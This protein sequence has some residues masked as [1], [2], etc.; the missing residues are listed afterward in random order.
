VSRGLV[1]HDG[2]GNRNVLRIRRT[3]ALLCSL[4]ANVWAATVAHAGRTPPHLAEWRILTTD[5]I[6]SGRSGPIPNRTAIS[7]GY[8]SSFPPGGQHTVLV[9]ALRLALA[10][11]SRWRFSMAHVQ[12][13]LRHLTPV[14]DRPGPKSVIGQQL[15]R[16]RLFGVLLHRLTACHCG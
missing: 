9:A 15:S 11:P 14:D 8:L 4:S 16:S 6:E 12:P 2:H 7:E 13:A 10:M 5:F 1:F 3:R